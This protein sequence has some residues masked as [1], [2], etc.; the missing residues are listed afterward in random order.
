M[1][2]REFTPTRRDLPAPVFFRRYVHGKYLFSADA[3]S[4]QTEIVEEALAQAASVRVDFD[5]DVFRR[6]LR[7]AGIS[8]SVTEICLDSV[9]L[10]SDGVFSSDRITW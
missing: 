1:S 3:C 8:E 4:V 7:S 2:D 5:D 10:V 6:A 9:Q